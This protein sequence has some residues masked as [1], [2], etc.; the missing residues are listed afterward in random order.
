MFA[1]RELANVDVGI[2][3]GANKFFLVSDAVVQR[4]SLSAKAHPMFGR[5]EH[6]PGII[7]DYNQHNENREKGYPSNFLY[8]D[9][10]QDGDVYGEYLAIGISQNIPSRYKCRI[11][12]PWYK[13]PS[14]FSTPVSMLKRSNGM[15]RL[16]LNRMNAYTTDTAY[17]IT[18]DV[19]VDAATLVVCF[20]N[21]VTALSAELEGRFYGGGVLELVPSEIERLTVP[22]MEGVGQNIDELNKD[23]RQMEGRTLLEKQDEL[24]FSNLDFAEFFHPAFENVILPFSQIPYTFGLLQSLANAGEALW[25]SSKQAAGK[26]SVQQYFD[27]FPALIQCYISQ[28]EFF[29]L[30][31]IYIAQNDYD[32][33]FQAIMSGIQKAGFEKDFRMLKYFCKLARLSGWCSREALNTLYN[34]IY[35]YR[36]FE[37]M[38]PFEQRNYYLNLGEIRNI[39]ITDNPDLPTLYFRFQSNILPGEKEN[40]SLLLDSIDQTVEDIPD[41]SISHKIELRHES[42]YDIL[43]VA[44]GTITALAYLANLLNTLCKP[45]GAMMDLKI[46][47]QTIQLNEQQLKKGEQ[48]IR[49]SEV[50]L[51]EL[52]E[53]ARKRRAQ[54]NKSGILLDGSSYFINDDHAV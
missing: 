23:V 21:S 20:L 47:Q 3:T 30:A 25:V 24:L 41:Q 17:R 26:I 4:Y 52:E 2:V 34:Y 31:N 54:L 28:Q 15:P 53:S 13:V 50:K 49:I 44:F 46:K 8:F 38:E 51:Q 16:I 45:V 7:Y 32:M 12:S 29:P 37:P 18:P 40:L 14:V 10:E 39:L 33:A 19:D 9:S 5:S 22:Y 1:F 43:V 27:L 35:D 6:C 42:P 48:D 36:H 11:R